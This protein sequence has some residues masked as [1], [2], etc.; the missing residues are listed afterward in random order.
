M[1][2]LSEHILFHLNVCFYFEQQLNGSVFM[3]TT[4]NV[5]WSILKSTAVLSL[6]HMLKIPCGTS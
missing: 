4:R 1:H 5:C 2:L 3:K 6:N